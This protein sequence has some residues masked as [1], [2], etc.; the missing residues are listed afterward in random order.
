MTTTERWSSTA[1]GVG[2]AALLAG[3][4]AAVVTEVRVAP[5]EA[6]AFQA[7]NRLPDRLWPI[8]WGPMQVGSFAGALVVAGSAARLPRGARVGAV[9]LTASQGA[10]WSA[11]LIKRATCRRRPSSLVVDAR[12]REVARG[13]GYVSGHAAVAFALATTLAPSTPRRWRP[14]LFGGAV[15]VGLARQYAGAHLPLDVIGGAGTGL[16]AGALCRR[17]FGG[18]PAP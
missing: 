11:K 14:A 6:G 12:I 13:P 18:T 15:F 1:T 17:A 7:V 16:L 4:W 3:S 10:Y 5:W 2:G 9:V 8:V